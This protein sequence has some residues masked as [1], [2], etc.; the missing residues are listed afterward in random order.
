VLARCKD[1][2]ALFHKVFHPQLAGNAMFRAIAMKTPTAAKRRA[3]RSPWSAKNFKLLRSAL[4]VWELKQR[5]MG[6]WW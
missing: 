2:A 1:C 4:K 3:R 5:S 6:N